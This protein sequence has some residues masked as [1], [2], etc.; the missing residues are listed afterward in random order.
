MRKY[1]E[2][3]RFYDERDFYCKHFVHPPI[4][5][6]QSYESQYANDKRTFL[7][8]GFLGDFCNF[9]LVFS[10]ISINL[11]TPH[12]HRNKKL[13]CFFLHFLD[14]K[15]QNKLTKLRRCMSRVHLLLGECKD[16]SHSFKLERVKNGRGH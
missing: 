3:F 16:R 10:L 1:R 14:H 6:T 9:P 13:K 4:I 7:Q 5:L 15:E 2:P 12:N 8:T 11:L